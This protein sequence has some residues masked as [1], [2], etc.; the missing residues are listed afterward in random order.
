MD[1]QKRKS[2]YIDIL[3]HRK[4]GQNIYHLTGNNRTTFVPLK[5]SDGAPGKLNANKIVILP[6]RTGCRMRTIPN[7]NLIERKRKVLDIHEENLKMVKRLA[8]MKAE[9]RILNH[10]ITPENVFTIDRSGFRSRSQ[11]SRPRS[12]S[13]NSLIRQ[14]SSNIG[15]RTKLETIPD[16]DD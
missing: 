15:A 12:T 1:I 3:E 2:N 7:S 8:D 13:N 14:M 5:G 4:D 16:M 11:G 9:Q 10:L 6:D